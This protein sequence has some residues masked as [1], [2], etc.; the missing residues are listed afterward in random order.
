MTSGRSSTH[1]DPSSA[2]ETDPDDETESIDPPMAKRSAI[3]IDSSDIAN[4]VGSS[5]FL[6]ADSKYNMLVNHFKPE[7]DYSFPK[8][9]SGRS[10][11]Y[12]WLVQ[13]PWLVVYS[14]QKNGGFCLPC[15]FFS[16][17]G[18][19]GSDPG[20]LVSCPLSSFNKALEIL[21]KHVDKSYHKEA[22][23]RSEDFRK[24]M[25]HQQPDI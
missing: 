13:F 21:W 2:S 5:R 9:S 14:K 12:K 25:S 4:V 1:E 15:V 7:T 3:T 20:V 16:T 23:V 8:S 6:N 24:V 18:Y 11:Q 19:R 22:V 10:F 17:C